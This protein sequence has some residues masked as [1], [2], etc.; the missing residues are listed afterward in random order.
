MIGKYIKFVVRDGL[1]HEPQEG[2]IIEKYRSG[3]QFSTSDYYIIQQ[4][5]TF[6]NF[7]ISKMKILKVYDGT[8]SS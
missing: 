8:P 4:K 1:P 5:D 7:A 6:N 3:N 2:K